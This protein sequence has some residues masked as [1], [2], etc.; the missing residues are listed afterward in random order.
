MPV[1]YARMY[2]CTKPAAKEEKA[3]HGG[4]GGAGR[5]E[6][7]CTDIFSAAAKSTFL[8]CSVRWWDIQMFICFENR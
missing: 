3:E 6:E 8:S 5:K 4:K 7:V 1:P 2:V